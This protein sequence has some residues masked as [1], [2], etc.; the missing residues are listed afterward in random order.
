MRL[1]KTSVKCAFCNSA[2]QKMHILQMS[3]ILT[4]FRLTLAETPYYQNALKIPTHRLLRPASRC[5]WCPLRSECPCTFW[6]PSP[7]ESMSCAPPNTHI[8]QHPSVES[9]RSPSVP[10]HNCSPWTSS[11]GPLFDLPPYKLQE[12]GCRTTLQLSKALDVNPFVGALQ[13]RLECVAVLLLNR[14]PGSVR[15][16]VSCV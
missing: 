13:A 4:R 6:Q 2:G 12:F 5:G 1:R 8:L 14:K 10:Y 16:S 15:Q 3:R 11:R 7:S 9:G